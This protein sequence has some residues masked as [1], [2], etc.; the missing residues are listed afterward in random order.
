MFR[1]LVVDDE[2]MIRQGFVRFVDWAALDCTV[3]AQAENGLAAREYLENHPVD[4][5]I[6]D[7]RMPE[8]DGIQLAKYAAENLPY[9]RVIILTAYADFS[10]AQTAIQYG[11]VDFVLKTNALSRIARPVEKAKQQI[12]QMREKEEQLQQLATQVNQ[13]QDALFEKVICDALADMAEFS[14]CQGLYQD[15]PVFREYHLLLFKLYLPAQHQDD[16]AQYRRVLRSLRELLGLAF[17][18]NGSRAVLVK[19]RQL[20]VLVPAGPSLAALSASCKN[21]LTAMQNFTSATLN[22]GISCRHTGISELSMAYR[23]AMEAS[24]AASDHNNINLYSARRSAEAVSDSGMLA[25]ADE[26]INS[27]LMHCR[28]CDEKQAQESLA[29]L[30][31]F[32]KNR[33]LA[34]EQIRTSCSILCSLCLRLLM[35]SQSSRMPDD[36][37]SWF[38]RIHEAGL[39]SELQEIM[40]SFLS[41]TIHALGSRF[42]YSNPLIQEIDRYLRQNYTQ[43]VTLPMLAEAVHANGSYLSRIYKKETGCSVIDTLN[44]LRIEHAKELLKNP[45]NRIFEVAIAVGIDNPTYFT[46]VFTKHTGISP[47]K[48]RQNFLME[49]R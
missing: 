48:Y 20:V 10:Y 38:T 22:I 42:Q 8:L 46:H 37:G 16:P 41:D 7:I 33:R 19:P 24:L 32:Y 12:L 30:F 36:N 23:E 14:S 15:A 6:T 29:S 17:P 21:V 27:I 43:N 2:E 47:A 40:K 35:S 1:V 18:E 34:L 3:V 11:V 5:L 39:I 31:G 49:I 28:H 26:M 44:Q 4:I 25:E 13:K 9:T 45:S